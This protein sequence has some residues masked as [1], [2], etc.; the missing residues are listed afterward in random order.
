MGHFHPGFIKLGNYHHDGRHL[1]LYV[2]SDPSKWHEA[3][4]T[5]LRL[6][7]WYVCDLRSN[8]LNAL[9]KYPPNTSTLSRLPLQRV[10]RTWTWCT[11]GWKPPWCS[12]LSIQCLDW[13][14]WIL[15]NLPNASR[16][17]TSSPKRQCSPR[18]IL[19]TCLICSLNHCLLVFF[20]KGT[21]IEE[22]MTFSASK[23]LLLY[24]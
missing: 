23:C 12:V 6:D 4:E 3:A 1:P 10:W 9:T 20:S 24:R 21:L 19:F 5:S 2:Y 13:I 22:S 16:C 14:T 8:P 18:L 15:P 7:Y 11:T 17:S